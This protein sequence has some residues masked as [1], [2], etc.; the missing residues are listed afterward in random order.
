MDGVA[1]VGRADGVGARPQPLERSGVALAQPPRHG[2]V[3]ESVK[4]ERH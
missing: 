3:V 2:L 4:P 1:H